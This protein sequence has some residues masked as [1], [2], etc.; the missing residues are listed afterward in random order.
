MLIT[1]QTHPGR[2]ATLWLT[3]MIKSLNDK[4]GVP[5]TSCKVAGPKLIINRIES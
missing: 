2:Y 4:I 1:I 3:L 5:N